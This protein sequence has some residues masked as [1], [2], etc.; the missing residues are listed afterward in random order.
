VKFNRA[1]GNSSQGLPVR[2]LL[3]PSL[4][5]CVAMA[6]RGQTTGFESFRITV[7]CKE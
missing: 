5:D 4:R 2:R 1:T 7:V 6:C 3:L